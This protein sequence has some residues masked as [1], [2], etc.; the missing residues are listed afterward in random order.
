MAP[1][2]SSETVILV[3]DDNA[4]VLDALRRILE[5]ESYSV[6][7]ALS[8]GEAQEL[9]SSNPPDLILS[10]MLMP[11]EDGFSFYERIRRETT[12]HDIPFIFL[13]A[14]VCEESKLRATRSGCDEYLLKPIE[15]ET[16]LAVVE[17]NL[18]KARHRKKISAQKMQ[19]LHKRIIHTLSHEFRTPLVSIQAGAE[20]LI[21]KS[22]KDEDPTTKLIL[23]AI[24]TGGRRLQRLVEDFMLLQQL[25]MNEKLNPEIRTTSIVELSHV[26]ENT[27]EAFV[28]QRRLNAKQP[29]VRF[30]VIENRGVKEV[31]VSS[32]YLSDILLRLLENAYKFGGSGQPIDVEVVLMEPFAEIIVRDYGPGFLEEPDATR[33]FEP[34]MQIKRDVY[35]Q[36]GC[37]VGLTI[38][39]FLAKINGCQL[40]F[41]SPQEGSGVAVHIIVPVAESSPETKEQ[42]HQPL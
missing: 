24:L 26:V 35:E 18:H 39:Q 12:L 41:S 11:D 37:G 29:V 22:S 42:H 4:E 15:P 3:V 19:N 8:P 9:L 16:L 6:V 23:E 1:K 33:V 40:H 5:A 32:D 31:Q 38:A 7:C 10:D 25:D 27:V 14:V 36:Q 28:S 20:L 17:G 34:F 30:S 13:T 21:E 2:E